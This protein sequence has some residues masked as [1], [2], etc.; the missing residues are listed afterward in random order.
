MENKEITIHD[1]LQFKPYKEEVFSDACYIKLANQFKEVLI[2][3]L[4]FTEDH[5]MQEEDATE[6]AC[7]FASLIEDVVSET[8]IYYT[9]RRLHKELYGHAIPFSSEGYD[10]SIAL[11]Y[12]D[13]RFLLWYYLSVKRPD[14]IIYLGSIFMANLLDQ[15]YEV[16][17]DETIDYKINAD[18]K[19][20][21][22]LP[23][24]A[25]HINCVRD[26]IDNIL[27]KTYL[28]YPDA[29]NRLGDF[30]ETLLAENY[31]DM[32][33]Q[34]ADD[35]RNANLFE[36]RYHFIWHYRTRLLALN[37]KEWVAKLIGKTHPFYHDVLNISQSIRAYFI[38]KSEN[39]D[40]LIVE[41]IA[42]GKP[43]EITKQSIIPKEGLIPNESILF[44][45]INQWQGKWWNSGI[46]LYKEFD[47]DLILDEKASVEEKLKIAFLDEDIQRKQQEE[48]EKQVKHFIT[49]NQNSPIAF[50]PSKDLSQFV[51]DY[52]RYYRKCENIQL[53][54]GV[55]A[56]IKIEI[57]DEELDEFNKRW[58]EAFVFINS[59]EGMEIS[60]NFVDIIPDEKNPYYKPDKLRDKFLDI[61]VSKHA[62]RELTQYY[63]DQY[64]EQL[65]GLSSEFDN[66]FSK[67]LDFL[68]RFWKHDMYFNDAE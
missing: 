65:S 11:N 10:E 46:V 3:D 5:G 25:C 49:F 57:E 52:T 62:S 27:F 67:N 12:S 23:H 68:S 45:S 14:T 18:L 34:Q 13:I 63:F 59:K 56:E 39:E 30:E 54:E 64:K 24:E 60:Y 47:A 41:H 4:Y 22:S 35:T 33:P 50:M 8:Q 16:I 58:T 20:H 26:L 1:W 51:N 36:N 32:S 48:S 37:G 2:N 40:D 66:T 31:S 38:Y 42:S 7:I 28:F 21:Y 43:F 53:P 15:L 17:S 61:I 29:F 19:R 55:S 6:F 9:F 44:L